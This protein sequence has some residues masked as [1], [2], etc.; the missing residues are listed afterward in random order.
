MTT[1]ANGFEGAI[2]LRLRVV[3]ARQHI[4]AVLYDIEMDVFE[5]DVHRVR[6]RGSRGLRDEQATNSKGGS[7]VVH[8]PSAGCLRALR[9]ARQRERTHDFMELYAIRSGIEGTV[10]QSVRMCG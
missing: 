9:A 6:R 8:R 7:P 1:A 5:R 10:C 4:V 3:V 2:N